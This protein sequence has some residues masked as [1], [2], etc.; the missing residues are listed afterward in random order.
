V[1]RIVIRRCDEDPT[2]DVRDI[3][4][5]CL[6]GREHE[7]DPVDLTSHDVEVWLAYDTDSLTSEPVAFG[8]LADRGHG[9]TPDQSGWH[10]RMSGTLP[11]YQ[12]Q[13]IQRRLIRARVAHVRAC[14]GAVVR[15]YT[16]PDNA[17]SLRALGRCGF[18]PYRPED[19]YA[20]DF[21]VYL[22]KEIA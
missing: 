16:R 13:G 5:A 19:R 14:G 7:A 18:V 4:A 10:L 20:G 6:D 1:T 15:T 9:P 21:M 17:E 2:D 11:E 12:R 3:E 8:V 22:R